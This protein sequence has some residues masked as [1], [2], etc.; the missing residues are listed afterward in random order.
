MRIY[1]GLYAGLGAKY[2]SIHVHGDATQR[3]EAEDAASLGLV[4]D[5]LASTTS[6]QVSEQVS[7]RKFQVNS[8]AQ[9]SLGVGY[10]SKRSFAVAVDAHWYPAL[11]Y[12]LLSGQRVRRTTDDGM[13]MRV[14]TDDESFDVEGN[15]V[16][17]L[18]VGG[19]VYVTEWLALRAGFFTDFSPAPELAPRSDDRQ[20]FNRKIDQFGGT[21]GLGVDIG[22]FDL[23]V[24]G[25]YVGGV[26]QVGGGQSLTR[27]EPRFGVADATESRIFGIITG[28]VSFG[29][30]FGVLDE[31]LEQ[32]ETP[33]EILD[34]PERL[35]VPGN[36]PVDSSAPNVVDRGARAARYGASTPAGPL[37]AP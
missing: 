11:S 18:N 28:G 32:F 35:L 33:E 25:G 8:P 27:P 17:N 13:G 21:V 26:G 14:A 1:E 5:G 6:R 12:S 36:D 16:F 10:E 4:L 15:H 3:V 37:R 7:A 29:E 9:L 22:A 23:T 20:L 31:R 34:K 30:A 19:E 24:G 2:Q